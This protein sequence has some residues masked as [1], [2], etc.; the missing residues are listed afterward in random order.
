MSNLDRVKEI[1]RRVSWTEWK[2]ICNVGL[3]DRVEGTYEIIQLD[4]V[5]YKDKVCLK[6]VKY[7]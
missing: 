5:K 2:D 4:M 7:T 1:V 3:L 6:R